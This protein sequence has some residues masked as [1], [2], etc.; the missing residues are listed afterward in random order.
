[1]EST[2]TRIRFTPLQ[3]FEHLLLMSLFIILLVTGLPQKFS[4]A[5][6]SVWTVQALGGIDMTRLIHR[7]SGILL[8]LQAVLDLSIVVFLILKGRMR[9]TMVPSRQDFVDAIQMARYCLGL[10]EKPPRFDR[11]DYR[12]KFEYWGLIFGTGIMVISG[13]I[14]YYPAFFTQILP[15]QLVPAAKTMHTNEALLALATIL[16]WHMYGAHLNPD[17]FPMDTSIFTGRISEERMHHEHPLELERI[18]AE[19]K[20][21]D[22]VGAPS[23]PPVPVTSG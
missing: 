7:W 19:E 3:R 13:F 21:V 15:G 6:W 12:Q 2:K 1:M 11:Y 17:V 20:A 9:P 10:V 5:G 16:I 22:V 14:L 18:L 4:D 8:A 23:E